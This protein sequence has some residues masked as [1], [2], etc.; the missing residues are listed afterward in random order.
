MDGGGGRWTVDEAADETLL[1]GT[2]QPMQPITFN[3]SHAHPHAR[4]GWR[5]SA[6]SAAT[7]LLAGSDRPLHRPSIGR[8]VVSSAAERPRA[9]EARARGVSSRARRSAQGLRTEEPERL[10]RSGVA[11]VFAEDSRAWGGGE[12]LFEVAGA[13]GVG[14]S[15]TVGVGDP[16]AAPPSATRPARGAS[17]LSACVGRIPR[18]LSLCWWR[19]YAR[20]R[21]ATHRSAWRLVTHGRHSWNGRNGRRDFTSD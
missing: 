7:P 17:P 3:P 4:E 5:A 15:Y 13:G 10:L 8:R 18:M 2:M 16:H 6:A 20:P 1:I 14:M 11:Q 21:C 12:L 9:P 19:L